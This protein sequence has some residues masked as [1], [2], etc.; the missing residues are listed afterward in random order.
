MLR[1]TI[2]DLYYRLKLLKNDILTLKEFI[3]SKYC[4]GET[5]MNNTTV[6]LTKIAQW[7][8]RESKLRLH[9]K[10]KYLVLEKQT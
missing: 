9:S 7:K 3:S 10:Y 1:N 2:S 8:S 4:L 5:W 6:W